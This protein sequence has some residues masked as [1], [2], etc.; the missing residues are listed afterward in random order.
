MKY[1]TIADI[2]SAN[3]EARRRLLDRLSGVSEDEAGL[4]PDG[5]TWSINQIAE[6]LA[7]VDHGIA[8]ICRRLIAQ[9]KEGGHLANGE[10]AISSEFWERIERLAV[11]KV[12][13]PEQV[14]PKGDTGIGESIALMHK[15]R[16]V[17]EELRMDMETYD[18]SAPKFPHPYFGPITA[19]EWLVI[20]GG[21]ELRH[22]EQIERRLKL[23]RDEKNPGQ[24]E[25]DPTGVKTP[26]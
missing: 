23:I 8:R 1:D 12:A 21:H 26:N 18:L 16:A 2:Y 25:G 15:N 7:M 14:H 10:M 13:A 5:E 3:E 20:A 11:E 22:T 19:V 17:F 4:V 24:K 6:H 9:A